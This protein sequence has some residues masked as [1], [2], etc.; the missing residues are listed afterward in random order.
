M[1]EEE[2]QTGLRVRENK[3]TIPSK[4]KRK[5]ISAVGVSRKPP[6][7]PRVII[8]LPVG[9]HLGHCHQGRGDGSDP[10]FKNALI[11]I[12]GAPPEFLGKSTP[13]HLMHDPCPLHSNHAANRETLRPGQTP[14]AAGRA[15]P[16]ASQPGTASSPDRQPPEPSVPLD[17]LPSRPPPF[18]ERPSPR[19][20]SHTRF[21]PVAPPPHSAAALFLGRAEAGAR[22]RTGRWAPPRPRSREVTLSRAAADGR[23]CRGRE[24]VC[25]RKRE[26]RSAGLAP[27]LCGILEVSSVSSPA[28]C[29][30][31][32]RP[33]LADTVAHPR[34]VP[35]PPPPSP[36]S[37]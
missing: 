22:M 25:G 34:G 12:A 33:A 30:A 24:G 15:P 9:D 18:Q 13:K 21:P 35:S 29:S 17:N 28:R 31:P 7:S 27:V 19:S 36:G 1:K 5:D 32:L 4:P 10:T 16:E 8:P 2:I 6:Q 26:A 20:R 3:T 23:P 37:R 14:R 11:G